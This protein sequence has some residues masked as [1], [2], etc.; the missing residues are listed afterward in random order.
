M[1]RVRVSAKD[2]LHHIR[3][4]ATD[5]VL[6]DKYDLSPRSLSKVK[7]ALLERGLASPAELGI[8]HTLPEAPKN[9]VNAKTFL[10]DFRKCPDDLFLM[11]KYS[12]S[13]EQLQKVYQILIEKG[14]LDEYEYHCRDRKAPE[15]TGVETVPP[16]DLT[17]VSLVEDLSGSL[18]DYFAIPASSLTKSR[19][20]ASRKHAS[21]S[22]DPSPGK[23]RQVCPNCGKLLG[24]DAG[25]SCIHCGVVFTKA[26]E[27]CRQDKIAIWYYTDMKSETEN[28]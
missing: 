2:F 18:R 28:G 19:A 9:R 21:S 3:N 23:P 4:G 10:Q 11:K 8:S 24:P 7:R 20:R 1:K 16:E 6:M 22:S 13:V 17:A 12:I 26:E 5:Q 14:L 25:T 15:L 27:R